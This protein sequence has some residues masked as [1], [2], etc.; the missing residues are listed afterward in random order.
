MGRNIK[1]EVI[2][3]TLTISHRIQK[4]K[5]F[6]LVHILYAAPSLVQHCFL[7]KIFLS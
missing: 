6:S 1:I 7:N 2:K 3:Q 5:H 4:T